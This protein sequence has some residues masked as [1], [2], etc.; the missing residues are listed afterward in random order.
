ML[1]SV[2][3][4]IST[5]STAGIAN[6]V[7]IDS[8]PNDSDTD[9]T[10]IGLGAG[11]AGSLHAVND[12]EDWYKFVIPVDGVVT[13]RLTRLNGDLDPDLSAFD[14]GLVS[15]GIGTPLFGQEDVETLDLTVNEGDIVFI[16]VEAYSGQGNYYLS[17]LF[18]GDYPTV[19]S[20]D[21]G[22]ACP[23]GS[24]VTL[25]GNGFG[26]DATQVNVEICDV[27]SEVVSAN[28]T[29]L[30]IAVPFG[31]RNGNLYVSV[32]GR[33]GAPYN[34]IIDSNAPSYQVPYSSE[35][36][37]PLP[38]STVMAPGGGRVVADT[39]D[40]SFLPTI[41]APTLS[42]TLS[43]IVTNLGY[44]GYNIVGRDP[45]DNTFQV[46][47]SGPSSYQDLVDLV[48][49]VE[50]HATVDGV[51]T[52]ILL[53][54][55]GM[56][57]DSDPMADDQVSSGDAS[58]YHA[59][60]QKSGIVD[61]WDLYRTEGHHEPFGNIA[62]AVIDGGFNDGG[63]TEEF[64]SNRF[65][66]KIRNWL[67]RWTV[68]EADAADADHGTG[69]ASVIG[70]A[71][72]YG[73]VTDGMNGVLAGFQA[74][75]YDDDADGNTHYAGPESIP[76]HITV[77][78]TN[79]HGGGPEDGKSA[80]GA[81]NRALSDVVKMSNSNSDIRVVNMSLGSKA[82]CNDTMTNTR[83][84]AASSRILFVTGAGN[85]GGIYKDYYPG[86]YAENLRN[87]VAV[88]ASYGFDPVLADERVYQY[89]DPLL[90]GFTWTSAE[91]HAP[92]LIIAPGDAVPVID[93]ASGTA[94]P[95]RMSGTSFAA[96]QVSAAAAVLFA[97]KP[98][99]KPVEVRTILSLGGDDI[100]GLTGWEQPPNLIKKRLNLRN[101]M[102]L[103]KKHFGWA[104]TEPSVTYAY[105]ANYGTDDDISSVLLDPAYGR[106]YFDQYLT[107]FVD[108]HD[109]GACATPVDIKV[110]PDGHRIYVV[111]ESTNSLSIL[112]AESM[113]LIRETS[114]PTGFVVGWGQRMT[115][116][117]EENVFIPMED[118]NQTV[119]AIYEG[120]TDSWL[121]S[122][123]G[124]QSIEPFELN[125]LKSSAS[126]I[127]FMPTET[128]GLE[129]IGWVQGYDTLY[130]AGEICE[131]KFY[132]GSR[133]QGVNGPN[134]IQTFD[135]ETQFSGAYYPSGLDVSSD[136]ANIVAVYDDD[137]AW[138]EAM[139]ISSGGNL[140]DWYCGSIASNSLNEF[141]D[142][143]IDPKNG[144]Y[145]YIALNSID[146]NDLANGMIAMAHVGNIGYEDCVSIIDVGYG[147]APRRIEVTEDGGTVISSITGL[148]SLAV[149]PNV[150][151]TH[152][153][154]VVHALDGEEVVYTLSE[155]PL[156]VDDRPSISLI[157]PRP[158]SRVEGVTTF[159]IALRDENF[160]QLTISL[161]QSDGSTLIQ[162]DF[163]EC[164]QWSADRIISTEFY[165][166][167][168]NGVRPLELRI[169]AEY[170]TTQ[171][172]EQF[173]RSYYFR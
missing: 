56:R 77:Y 47:F 80:R 23:Y 63:S 44:A 62:I 36:T 66:G 2:C 100:S 58:E 81:I 50:T 57:W 133:N 88:A 152:I 75:L 42:S 12:D 32:A 169:E 170:T 150:P 153:A 73:E 106:P 146:W 25:T 37:T 7:W 165:V 98:Q 121:D 137:N 11:G 138:P 144:E 68:G 158:E 120:R 70:A 16:L 55:F 140:S 61:A 59:A 103:L 29:Q 51:S 123:T 90:G 112:D 168:A 159:E 124:T 8:E 115:I 76:Y 113:V 41:G 127:V 139:T 45:W 94:I 67:G 129:N 131:F 173:T 163:I 149:F 111:C 3:I 17:L 118:G 74:D 147:R 108:T 128:P 18:D 4:F 134:C 84:V 89:S 30:V 31:A 52:D 5:I 125:F 14:S 166:N 24:Q 145:V 53:E 34:L 72:R 46:R 78:D 151:S 99:L 107:P 15:L 93:V 9:A 96:P 85:D 97:S 20:D 155:D 1:V 54:P 86:C 71:N 101:S 156:G 33:V 60:Y 130:D 157:S 35:Y 10:E 48:A 162:Q 122:N 69:V 109:P 49:E 105:T 154:D 13:L 167:A 132:P 116:D 164:E 43:A 110:S 119:L 141:K 92:N 38:G 82:E 148:N 160:R 91:G 21:C 40:I 117:E 27:Q 95:G 172:N 135:I 136:G 22:G 142:V 26:T 126:D 83:F 65:T 143:A 6:A 104:E 161:Y 171:P 114:L 64:P 87:V 79:I 102:R 19:F 39:I 28:S